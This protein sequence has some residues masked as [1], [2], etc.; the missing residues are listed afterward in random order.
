MESIQWKLSAHINTN[1][2]VRTVTLH[3]L[4][5]PLSFAGAYSLILNSP[6]IE[7]MLNAPNAKQLHPC[8]FCSLFAHGR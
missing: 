6:V 4:P 3:Q 5:S 1:E 2:S 8:M 7:R